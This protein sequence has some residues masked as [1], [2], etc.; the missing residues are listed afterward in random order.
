M[1]TIPTQLCRKYN[2]S[3]ESTDGRRCW[4]H[5]FPYDDTALNSKTLVPHQ[6]SSVVS[7]SDSWPGG[8]KFHTRFRRAFFT[9]CPAR[10]AQWWACRTHDLVVVSSI[11]GWGDFSFR[12]IFT[13]HLCRSMW[14]KYLVALERKVVLMLV[15]ESQET[16]MHHRQP[17]DYFR[18][19]IVAIGCPS[20]RRPQRT[21]SCYGG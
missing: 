8:C 10:V 17:F 4:R 16:H 1:C 18:L 3:T 15:W 2:Q 21:V 6:G 20:E 13:S 14:E 19:F 12:R 5:F 7:G 11:P 9:A